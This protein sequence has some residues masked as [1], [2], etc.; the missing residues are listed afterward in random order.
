MRLSSVKEMSEEALLN[1]HFETGE[2]MR[3]RN[4]AGAEIWITGHGLVAAG[5]EDAKKILLDIYNDDNSGLQEILEQCSLQAAQASALGHQQGSSSRFEITQ[6]PKLCRPL[7]MMAERQLSTYCFLLLN[8]LRMASGLKRKT[9]EWGQPGDKPDHHPE[10]IV[11]WESFVKTPA[12]MSAAEFEM[13]AKPDPTKYPV[14]PHKPK[15]SDFYRVLILNTL[16]SKNADPEKHV[17]KAVFTK[18]VQKDLTK[19]KA[20]RGKHR[21]PELPRQQPALQ[22]NRASTPIQHLAE[23]SRRSPP[24]LPL[25]RRSVSTTRTRDSLTTSLRLQLDDSNDSELTEPRPSFIP[26]ATPASPPEV[27]SFHSEEQ[28]VANEWENIR[29]ANIAEREALFQRL[30][31]DRAREAAKEV[32][33]IFVTLFYLFMTHKF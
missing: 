24:A 7:S 22:Q 6:P 3:R 8:H 13:I 11:N 23:L 2:E 18:K 27:P 12:N 26:P 10:E 14:P 20:K 9:V 16:L 30:D 31:I 5:N 33:S 15:K 19:G 21:M 1:S 17:D 28:N 32:N 29:A 4:M 25:T